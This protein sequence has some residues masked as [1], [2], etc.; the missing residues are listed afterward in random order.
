MNLTPDEH[1]VHGFLQPLR[2]LPPVTRRAPVDHRRGRWFHA[3]EFG[4]VAIAVFLLVGLIALL[5]HHQAPA[6]KP[7]SPPHHPRGAQLT[8]LS[9]GDIA[10]G[11]WVNGA[12]RHWTLG[13][14]HVIAFAWSP[15]GHRLAYLSGG[16]SRLSSCSLEILTLKSPRAAGS[17]SSSGLGFAG[18]SPCSRF[19][20][21][22]WSPSGGRVAYTANRRLFVVN[23]AAQSQ[24][25]VATTAGGGFTWWPGGRLAYSCQTGFTAR[26]DDWCA[27]PDGGGHQTMLPVHGLGVVWS[28]VSGRIAYLRSVGTGFQVWTASID[29]RHPRRLVTWPTCCGSAASSLAWAP[30][31]RRLVA[32]GSAAQIIDAR[33]GRVT[34]LAWWSS[35][36]FRGSDPSWH[37]AWRR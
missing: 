36:G 9:H 17:V 16:P 19:D 3:A 18:R 35:P 29:G 2:A 32:A 24:R 23:P 27:I 14:Q 11:P 4:G 6:E 31:G 28:P 26:L 22:M 7:I 12:P 33:T 5:S 20:Q 25:E 8:Y 10:E 37:P 13:G 34:P 30:D 21:V 15:N 1:A